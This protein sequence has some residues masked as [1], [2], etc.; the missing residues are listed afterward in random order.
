MDDKFSDKRVK[1]SIGYVI[2][3][4]VVFTLIRA[5][6]AQLFLTPDTEIAYSDFKSALRSDEVATVTVSEDRIDG[7]N[8]DG[9]EFYTVRVEDRYLLS[10]HELQARLAVILA[11]R[12][13]E[14]LVFDEISTGA[15]DDLSRATDLARRMVTEYGMSPALGPVRLAADPQQGAYLGGQQGL[16]ARVSPHTA[17]QVDE[18]TRQIVE[19][20]LHEAWELLDTH[21]PA[22]D[23]LAAQLRERE[24]VD[25]DEVVA[26]LNRTPVT[27]AQKNT[28]V[29]IAG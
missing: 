23:E 18:Q 21:K 20:G 13:A 14:A 8:V 2:A 19:A 16:D 9:T 3:A 28:P 11:G 4:L 24:S 25:G 7:A 5:I 12:A 1:F 29:P 10:E 17:A 26:I 6:V 27:E 15:A 22:L